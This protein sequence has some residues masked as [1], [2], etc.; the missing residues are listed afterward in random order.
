MSS[1]NVFDEPGSA[2]SP[3]EAA[4]E[5]TVMRK[6]TLR[7]IPFIFLMYV[8]NILDRVNVGFARLQMLDELDMTK[9]MYGF[10]FGVFYIGY[11]VFEVPSNLILR[12]VGARRWLARILMSW[13]AISACTMFVVDQWSF[14]LLRFLLGFAEAG[15]F[16][17]I[18]LYLTYWFPA[19]QRARAVARFMT[20]SAVTGIVGNP[21]SGAILQYMDGVGG[22]SGWQWIF[23]LEGLPSI[24][25]GFIAL[26][27]LTDRPELAGWLTSSERA[28][29][30]RRM[31]SEE[32][33]REQRHGF[34]LGKAMISGRVWLLCLLY[35][36]VAMGSNSFG[37]EAPNIIRVNFQDFSKLEI[38]LVA[39]V[40]SLAAIV[41]MVT[42][43]MHSDRTGERRWH[44]ACPAFVAAIGWMMVAN[45]ES[46]YLVLLGLALAQAGM[47]SM[48][49]PFWS[50]ATSF[51]SGAA[52]A[53]VIALINSIGNLGGFVGPTVI[54]A[55][56]DETGSYWGG[57]MFLAVVLVMG[58]FLAIT[59]R[60]ERAMEQASG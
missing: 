40:P 32:E 18:I 14:Y 47:L 57:L 35:S 60:H 3:A 58:G 15:F 39:A 36:T 29:L 25:L 2:L 46:R 33:S 24:V 9:T 13:G 59:A 41:A 53:G 11:F 5:K 51:L 27:Y 12:R 22:L 16:P 21:I 55:V 19:H 7:L 1:P 17:G 31:K 23:L 48:L 6:V 10:G 56:L 4:F 26:Y 37:S 52:A 49:A 30:T 43:A 42:I 54:G 45:L 34:T 38:G 28:W 44:V 8:L 20:G 50:L